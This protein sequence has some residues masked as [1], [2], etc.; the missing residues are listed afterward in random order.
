MTTDG[1]TVRIGRPRGLALSPATAKAR[2][3]TAS[4][5][6]LDLPAAASLPALIDYA[7][8][9]RTGEGGFVR[10]HEQ[11]QDAA[12][13]EAGKGKAGGVS[14][15]LG[16][17][18]FL[19][20]S[21]LSFEAIGVLD[22]L[23]KSNPAMLGDA[24]FRGLRGAARAMA[25][26]YKDAQADFSS[27]V[28]VEDPSSA[29]WRGYVAAKL[30]DNSG[31]R[32]QFSH[33]RSVLPM[34]TP[35]WRSRFARM[36][37]EAALASG[38]LGT[39]RNELNL[40]ASGELSPVDHEAVQLT[41]AKLSE[42]ENNP[43]QALT[44]YDLVARSDYGA[45]AAPAILRATQLRLSKGQM[46]PED[47]VTTLDALRFRW[48]G[49]STELDAVR[50]LGHIYLQQGNWREALEAL[51]SAGQQRS[52]DQPASLAVAADMSNAFRALFLDGQADGMQ[53]IQALALF[54]DF[55]DLTPIGADGDFMV[56][57]MVK[58]L[59]SVDLLTQASELLK[60]QVD[61]RLNGVAKAQV[62]T[63]LAIVD[64]MDKRPEDALGAL[65]DSRT[66][67]L[68]TAL[69][70]QRRIVEARALMALGRGD[71]ALEILQSDKSTEA[72]DIRAEAQW[73]QRAWPQ[74][75]GLFEAELGDRWKVSQPLSG[76]EQGRLMRAAIAYSLAGDDGGLTRLRT[77]YAK[78]AEG[79]SAPDAMRV[80]LSGVS[81]GALTVQDFAKASSDTA[82]FTGWVAAMKKRFS[83]QP[84]WLTGPPAPAQA[85][86]PVAPAPKAPTKAPVRQ[87]QAAPA[88]AGAKKG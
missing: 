85:A 56:R 14:A 88:K 69:N 22:G 27:T 40:A 29:L 71:H 76:E 55:K 73:K 23:A 31:A 15:R 11:L 33:G 75:G 63:D 62:A 58:R 17:A 30:G 54:Y 80:A 43:A 79:S 24:E 49:D 26:R 83:N 7:A 81:D 28:L 59:V 51:R 13:E 21:E 9:S 2:A 16:L 74:A 50:A 52:V 35:Q 6:T 65:N 86:A 37:A 72:S 18:R 25:G 82:A 57:K 10:R 3:M 87:A 64:L 19:V 41:Q 46:K 36:D 61:Q 44:L 47:A 67:L 66:T 84:T 70:T 68:P 48:R 39:A 42:A 5:P 45:L 77:R 4:A 20:G 53:P 78:L 34:F 1:D 38:D 8:W 32:D 12:A 60:Y